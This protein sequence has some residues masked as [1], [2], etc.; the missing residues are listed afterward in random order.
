MMARLLL[1]LALFALAFKAGGWWLRWRGLR[2]Q[3]RAAAV[4]ISTPTY[5]AE[6]LA[7][8]RQRL[9]DLVRLPRLPRPHFHL[10][11]FHVRRSA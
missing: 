3:M 6:V 1:E 11:R 7:V 5:L 8:Y 10:P 2:H 4:A 9:R